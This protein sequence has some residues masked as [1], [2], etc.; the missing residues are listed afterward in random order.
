MKREGDL[1]AALDRRIGRIRLIRPIRLKPPRHGASPESLSGPAV[2][3]LGALAGPLKDV[4][5]RAANNGVTPGRRGPTRSRGASRNRRPALRP[6]ARKEGRRLSQRTR[7]VLIPAVLVLVAAIA[8]GCSR[9]GGKAPDFTLANVFTGE[10]VQLSGLRG[11]PVA[12]VFFAT[13]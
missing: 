9:T 12:L 13:W 10:T 1:R 4:G 8:A 11:K 3:A 2:L 7:R 5:L 6:D